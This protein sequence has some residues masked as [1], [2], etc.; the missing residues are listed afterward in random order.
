ME[1]LK[2]LIAKQSFENCDDILL[3]LKDELKDKVQELKIF[4]KDTKVF[5]AGINTKLYDIEP[6]VLSGHIDTVSANIELYNTNPYELTEID[7][8]GYGLGSIDMKSFTAVVMDRLCEIKKVSC[9]H[10]ACT[11]NR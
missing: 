4:G 6:I 8:K 11:Y 2:K 10:C 5:L 7:G 9:P 1:N 3:F